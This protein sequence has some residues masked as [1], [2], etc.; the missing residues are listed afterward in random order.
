MDTFVTLTPIVIAI[1]S[2]F[3]VAHCRKHNSPWIRTW[4][5]A[6]SV[7]IGIPVSVYCIFMALGL[8]DANVK[9]IL[10]PLSFMLFNGI[11]SVLGV[12]VYNIFSIIN[13][14]KDLFKRDA[15]SKRSHNPDYN[16]DHYNSWGII[17][18][19]DYAV[20]NDAQR[21]AYNRENIYMHDEYDDDN[22]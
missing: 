4:V 10:A 18:A 9:W 7:L 17:Y 19:A 20:A 3:W 12:F 6:M 15:G 11:A 13:A 16:N 5:K 21:E 22:Y 14:K 8:T 1:A 2:G